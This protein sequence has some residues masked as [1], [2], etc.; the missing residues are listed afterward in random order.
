MNKGVDA[1][2]VCGPRPCGQT[3][4]NSQFWDHL[5]LGQ[6]DFLTKLKF[7]EQ[8]IL[9]AECYRFIISVWSFFMFLRGR[10]EG[11][12]VPC[13]SQGPVENVLSDFLSIKEKWVYAKNLY[14]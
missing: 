7:A 2:M 8:G 10:K 4:T 6:S 11:S 14:V 5:T 9:E 3:L 1:K 12:I 13:I